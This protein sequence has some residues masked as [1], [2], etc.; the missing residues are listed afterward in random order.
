MRQ[1]L[2]VVNGASH[3]EQVAVPFCPEMM[4]RVFNN[5]IYEKK[6]KLESSS[7]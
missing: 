2:Q 4:T 7:G 1:L 6:I 5:T 3:S